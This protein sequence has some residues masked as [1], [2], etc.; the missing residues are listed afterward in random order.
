[1]SV[2]NNKIPTLTEAVGRQA[3]LQKSRPE[4]EPSGIRE[5]PELRARIA[6]VCC[7]IVEQ[8]V[9]DA[10]REMEATLSNEVVSRLRSRL[11]ELIDETLNGELNQAGDSPQEPKR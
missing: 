9:H 8:V 5:L 4:P 3:A 2:D 11:P 10:F 1:M 7:D 6:A